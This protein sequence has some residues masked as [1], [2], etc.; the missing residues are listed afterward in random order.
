M[1]D[2]IHNDVV[3]EID[4]C[5]QTK[6]FQE[7]VKVAYA[8]SDKCP[9]K[10]LYV[11]P[12]KWK[13]AGSEKPSTGTEIKNGPLAAALQEQVELKK[14][15]WADLQIE[16]KKEEWKDFKV[17]FHGELVNPEGKFS[18]SN[19][20]ADL[21]SDSYI[22]FGNRYFKP[23]IKPYKDLFIDS[24]KSESAARA[25]VY[26]SERCEWFSSNAN[27]GKAVIDGLALSTLAKAHYDLWLRDESLQ[28][29]CYDADD[30]CT[31]GYSAHLFH[32]YQR[33]YG[34]LLELQ[35]KELNTLQLAV[36]AQELTE[37]EEAAL[38]VEGSDDDAAKRLE[39]AK[40]LQALALEE[41]VSRR[42]ITDEKG[43]E[44][45]DETTSF[46]PLM[47]HLTLGDLKV[48]E[49]LLQARASPEAVPTKDK[50]G[51]TP[52]LWACKEED[53]D[54]TLLLLKYKANIEATDTVMYTQI[55]LLCISL[56]VMC[57]FVYG[58]IHTYA[59]ACSL[60]SNLIDLSSVL[61]CEYWPEHVPLHS[62][63]V[64]DLPA[65]RGY[66]ALAC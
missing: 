23:E 33:S 10:D 8:G 42:W 43:L 14:G 13:E 32:D 34:K 26:K 52:L 19:C 5:V 35:R 66:C 53:V 65:E 62:L 64:G 7:R 59:F 49:R 20:A 44:H 39:A 6:Q 15:E 41:C 24:I 54:A 29:I 58:Y 61:T 48:A 4:N 51:K 40:R 28:W 11:S 31:A 37:A 18:R 63:D 27:L 45:L 47:T 9:D 36:G 55:C 56:Q 2:T 1:F 38:E 21:S 57:V 46:T 16:F 50:E 30:M 60:S 17:S 12:L 3:R 25:E 22:K